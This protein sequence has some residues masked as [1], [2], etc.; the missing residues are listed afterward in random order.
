MP[1]ADVITDF[2]PGEDR[3][4][5]HIIDANSLTAAN[6]AFIFRGS[7]QYLDGVAG[8]IRVTFSGGITVVSF[9][10]DLS[11]TDMFIVLEGSH[12]LT[13]NDFIL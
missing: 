12:T 6:D 8:Q 13:E 5:V 11:G 2:T 7:Q 9:R 10:T 1:D 3:I 4:S